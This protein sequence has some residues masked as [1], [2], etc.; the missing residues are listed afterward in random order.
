MSY[1]NT[2]KAGGPMFTAALLL[3]LSSSRSQLT[4]QEIKFKPTPWYVPKAV[5]FLDNFLIEHPDSQ[6]LEFGAGGSTIWLA[7]RAG[8]VLSIEHNKKWWSGILERLTF[9]GLRDKVDLR[10][11]A[12]PYYT[13]CADMPDNFF[14]VII[15][16]GRNRKGCISHSIDLLKPGGVLILD[17]SDRV[18]YHAVFG[19]MEGWQTDYGLSGKWETRWWF[20]PQVEDRGA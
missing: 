12:P 15:V 5:A 20:K 4:A 6:V 9:L 17:N 11:M 10:L 2:F 18:Y 13:V 8:H 19:L 16:D 1:L 3:L 7:S 14:D